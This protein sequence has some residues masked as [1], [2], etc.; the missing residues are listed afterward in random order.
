M[1][2]LKQL[3]RKKNVS[4]TDLAKGIGVSLRT[5]QLYEKKDANIPIKNLTKIAEFFE[6]SIGELYSREGVRESLGTYDKLDL[7]TPKAHNRIIKLA[8][9]RYLVSTPL[10][11]SKQQ[12]EYISRFDNPKF[13]SELPHMDMFIEQVSVGRYVAF[14]ITNNSM[15]NGGKSSIPDK[16]VV[17][18]KLVAINKIQTMLRDYP[19]V[20][21]ILIHRNGI[22]CKK[23]V[24]YS[25]KEKTIRCNSLNSSP[26]Y[27]DFEI[28]VDHINQLFMVIKKQVD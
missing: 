10:I 21:W 8:P 20:A 27:S 12:D 3:R 5:I 14:E 26:E 7:L 13:L 18:G 24:S 23:I 11:I 19:D 28:H 2:I 17:L 1:L 6:L 9:G 16:S 15:D 25:K 22:M 4:Q